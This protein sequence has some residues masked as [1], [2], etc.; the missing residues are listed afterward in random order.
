MQKALVL[1]TQKA[2][3]P[4][5]TAIPRPEVFLAVRC[6]AVLLVCA[7][8]TAGV[9]IEG[10]VIVE[11]SDAN[12]K[13]YRADVT[14]K[15]LLTG[16]VDPP[17]FAEGLIECITRRGGSG[18]D[19]TWIDDAPSPMDSP[20]LASAGRNRGYSFGS[21]NSALGSSTNSN[22]GR[23]SPLFKPK[24]PSS[25]SF[26]KDKDSPKN[27][28]RNPKTSNKDYFTANDDDLQATNTAVIQ[29]QAEDNW[30]DGRQSFDLSDDD[31]GSY[32]NARRGRSGTLLANSS[33]QGFTNPPKVDPFADEGGYQPRHSLD[34]LNSASTASDSERDQFNFNGL[35]IR[36]KNVD[37]DQPKVDNRP[38]LPKRTSTFGGGDRVVALFDFSSSEVRCQ[39]PLLS[40]QLSVFGYWTAG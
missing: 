25:F 36:Q 32:S 3:S 21:P 34:S 17:H 23:S 7:D 1:S 18:L 30:R 29:H 22:S 24:L 19:S 33:S 39:I 27:S 12:A 4:Q 13:A 9:S 38:P 16:Q 26:R 11:R 35:E 37:L 10:S 28:P 6:C 15:Q 2:K 20:G 8:S 31:D 14:V 5:C 40:Y